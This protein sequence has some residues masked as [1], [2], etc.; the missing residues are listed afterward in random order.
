[1][2]AFAEAPG[3]IVVTDSYDYDAFGNEVN[4]T[5]TTPNNYLY[6]GEQYDPDLGLY[7]LRARYYN[8]LTGR[9]MSRDPW[10]GYKFDPKTLHKY[11]YA[12]DDPINL[13][14]PTGRA[15]YVKPSNDILG[16][17]IAEYAGIISDISF[18]L[19]FYTQYA[20]PAYLGTTQGKLVIL[21]ALGVLGEGETISCEYQALTQT[22][23]QAWGLDQGEPPVHCDPEPAPDPPGTGPMAP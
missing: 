7:Y 4:H 3:H 6:R 2:A 1:V 23:R 10:S 11:L 20:L 13:S 21:G 16:N 9:F 15:T 19:A 14:D 8:P 17:A 12:A 5:G 18:K 22:L